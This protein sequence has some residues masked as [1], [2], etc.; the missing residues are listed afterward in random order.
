MIFASFE[1]MAKETLD[2]LRKGKRRRVGR[3]RRRSLR[4][5]LGFGDGSGSSTSSHE[6]CLLRVYVLRFA[7]RISD[8]GSH[9][10]SAEKKIGRAIN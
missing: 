2:S 6:N 3:F 8:K 1:N 9:Q 7:A 5:H 4:L 10:L